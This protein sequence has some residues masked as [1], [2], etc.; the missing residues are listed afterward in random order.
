MGFMMGGGLGDAFLGI[1]GGGGGGFGPRFGHRP[2][3]EG[4]PFAHCTY[5][6]GTG[7]VECDPIT[8][9]GLTIVRSA[10]F[11]DAAGNGQTGFDSLTTN[12]I[13]TRIS[14]NG[15]ITRRD[16]ATSDVDSQ[17]DRTVAGLAPGSSQRTVNGTSQGHE[18]TTG[19]DPTGDF[20]AERVA[21]ASSSAAWHQARGVATAQGTRVNHPR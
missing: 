9:G 1:G 11:L 7:R 5:N 10:S 2:P 3:G 4:D 16:G 20:T 18:L 13:N 15:T 12:T 8:R 14:V 6:A 17:S 21:G 19:T